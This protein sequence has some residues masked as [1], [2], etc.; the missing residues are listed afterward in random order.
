M[1]AVSGLPFTFLTQ[2]K[3]VQEKMP[4][5]QQ[6]GSSP[7]TIPEKSDLVQMLPHP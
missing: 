7:L 2:G 1:E 6:L 3:V 5:N 4:S